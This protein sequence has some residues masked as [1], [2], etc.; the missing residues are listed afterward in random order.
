MEW[1]QELCCGQSHWPKVMGGHEVL[2]SCLCIR[3]RLM[4]LQRLCTPRDASLVLRLAAGE[5]A[6]YRACPEASGGTEHQIGTAI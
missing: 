6:A 1:R 4:L 5:V 3:P 2:P